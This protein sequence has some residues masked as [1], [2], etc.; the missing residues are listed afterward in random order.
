L[1]GK[2]WTDRW[3]SSHNLRWI[4]SETEN[5]D[6]AVAPNL[7][8]GYLYKGN[9]FDLQNRLSYQIIKDV[10]LTGGIDFNPAI[11]DFNAFNN[12][13]LVFEAE[14]FKPGLIRFKI[15]FEKG[16]YY[17]VDEDV[18]AIYGMLHFFM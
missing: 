12:W 2:D 5:P 1:T 4:Y 6:A 9:Y 3:S 11:N 8:S 15:G 16:F 18:N 17:N 10:Y 7:N 13:D 14:L